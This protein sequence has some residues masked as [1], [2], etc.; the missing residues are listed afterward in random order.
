MIFNGGRAITGGIWH[1]ADV[2]EH[3]P[4]PPP[5]DA[6]LAVEQAMVRF[7]EPVPV[8]G[9][10]L[11]CDHPSVHPDHRCTVHTG[12]RLVVKGPPRQAAKQLID[13]NALRYAELHMR[14]A[15]KAAD[16]GDAEPTQWALEHLGVVEPLERKG[17]S[18]GVVVQIGMVLPG[19]REPE[20]A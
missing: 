17:P 11:D 20:D 14:A 18:T 9:K 7:E 8:P 15:E 19:L 3:T 12:Y 5:A 6:I 10:C 16:K 2:D 4:A 1:S 13:A